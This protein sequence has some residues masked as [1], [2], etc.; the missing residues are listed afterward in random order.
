MIDL[1]DFAVA[2]LNAVKFKHAKPVAEV[3]EFDEETVEAFG[4]E[5]IEDGKRIYISNICLTKYNS[6]GSNVETI[7]G[8]ADYFKLDPVAL[9]CSYEINGGN[10]IDLIKP[11]KDIEVFVLGGVCFT[12]KA[13]SSHPGGMNMKAKHTT[14]VAKSKYN[15]ILSNTA[16]LGLNVY[17][18]PI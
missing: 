9:F 8:I 6:E 12:S 13:L 11:F 18:E 10:F 4:K 16:I 7:Q 5:L 14:A 15:R 1:H 3:L 2:T 17:L